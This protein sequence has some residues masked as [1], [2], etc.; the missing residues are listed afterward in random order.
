MYVILQQ[1][2]P[3]EFRLAEPDSEMQPK[4]YAT[5]AKAERR[6]AEMGGV[7]SG[8]TAEPEEDCTALL[9]Y[10]ERWQIQYA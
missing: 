8:Y 4:R 1:T 10:G 9:T 5:R 2:N 6:A 7:N 3:R